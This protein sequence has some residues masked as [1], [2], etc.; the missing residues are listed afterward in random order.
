MSLSIANTYRALLCPLKCLYVTS[1]PPL[2]AG[3]G[4]APGWRDP[5]KHMTSAPCWLSYLYLEPHFILWAHSCPPQTLLKPHR[6]LVIP[7][8]SPLTGISLIIKTSSRTIGHLSL[9]MSPECYASRS[10]LRLFY[11]TYLSVL[12]CAGKGLRKFRRTRT[13]FNFSAQGGNAGGSM[14]ESLRGLW[15]H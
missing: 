4:N 1:I 14:N 8:L 9:L 15:I 3:L 13:G 2:P 7:S 6:G 11:V 5:N 12:P 10:V